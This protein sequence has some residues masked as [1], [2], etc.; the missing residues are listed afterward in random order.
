MK[1][2]EIINQ[3]CLMFNATAVKYISINSILKQEQ[4]CSESVSKQVRIHL[5]KCEIKRLEMRI[6][7]IL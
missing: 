2:T 7:H 4:E 1:R 6:E 5:L 3:V